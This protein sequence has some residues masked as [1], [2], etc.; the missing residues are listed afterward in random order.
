MRDDGVLCQPFS[1]NSGV[2]QVSILAPTLFLLFTSDLLIPTSNPLHCL[3]DDATSHCSPFTPNYQHHT[4]LP[5]S[6][7]SSL[8]G[9]IP[10]IFQSFQDPSPFCSTQTLSLM[11]PFKFRLDF[12]SL[13]SVT[14]ITGLIHKF[15][16][17]LVFFCVDLTLHTELVF[18]SASDAFC[19][20]PLPS[21]TQC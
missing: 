5:A 8:L 6:F 1:V 14:S 10:T 15:S 18:Y 12:F 3:P 4:V 2:S 7:A 19:T 11:S 17:L 9:A 21:F 16:S 13:H 20:N